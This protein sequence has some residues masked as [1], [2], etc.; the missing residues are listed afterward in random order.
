MRSRS[1]GRLVLLLLFD[2]LLAIPATAAD[3][4]SPAGPLTLREAL[5]TALL[6][7]P[8][9]AVFSW[10]LRAKEA[11]VLQAGLL[12]NPELSTEIE[13][14]GGT[15]DR[16]AFEQ[17][18]IT[19]S[20]AQLIE[21]GGK[22]AK[23]LRLAALDRDLATWDYEVARLNV[24]AGVSK[25]FTATLAAQQRLQLFGELVGLARRSVAA[26][27]TQVKAGAT[28]PVELMRAEAALG[29]TETQLRQ[30]ERDLANARTALAVT[31]G[32][33][34]PGFTAVV[35]DLVPVITPPSVGNLLDAIQ[36]NPDVARWVTE[37]EQRTAA[38]AVEKA[39]AI[40][41]LTVGL[42][43]RQ[44]TDNGDKA[45]VAGFSLPLPLF[46]RNQG[47]I[48]AADRRL[49]QAEAAR[50]RATVAVQRALAAAYED[51]RAAYAQ[52]VTLRD[53][54]LPKAEGA[55]AGA[56]D[57]Y[58]RGLLRFLDVLD[59]QRTLFET[60]DQYVQTLAAYHIAAADIE[61]LSGIPLT[62]TDLEE[63]K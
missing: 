28:S 14:F 57:A 21:L 45:L 54:V 3:L 7:S 62:G 48:L 25:A 60:R 20:L 43:G 1:Q 18:Q 40:P 26:V 38:L 33:A 27:A 50:D 53:E 34:T 42:G 32:S 10:E 11:E 59:A 63:G 30:A 19:V 2:V 15:G 41:S 51:L 49:A 17:T 4:P 9:L 35:G 6:G 29:R 47:N 58:Q 24:V 37:I 16:L 22:R 52:V 12:P 36:S 8:E 23:R 56:R 44:F 46:N 55:F 5:A 61:R 39:R 31:W 13:D